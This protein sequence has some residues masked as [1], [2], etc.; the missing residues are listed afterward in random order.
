MD[1]NGNSAS[2]IVEISADGGDFESYYPTSMLRMIDMPMIEMAAGRRE[3]E[4]ELKSEGRLSY[5]ERRGIA[6]AL[7]SG[8]LLA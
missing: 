4:Q 6:A 1:L 2:D 7:L 3:I 8:H 5:P